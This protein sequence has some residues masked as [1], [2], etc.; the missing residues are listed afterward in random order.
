[1]PEWVNDYSAT[2]PTSTGVANVLGGTGRFAGASGSFLGE[3][4]PAEITPGVPNS[5]TG[6][7]TIT[8]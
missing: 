7:G 1:M 4:S 5:L 6:E 8:Y 3:I 2:P